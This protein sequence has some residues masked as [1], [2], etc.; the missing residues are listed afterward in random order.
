MR[1]FR[2]GRVDSAKILLTA[3]F[4]TFVLFPFLRMVINIKPEDFSKV[5][6]SPAFGT[7]A[8]N[9]LLVSLTTTAIS[10]TIAL[11]LA[12]SLQRTNVRFRSILSVLLVM[13][14]LIPS[15]SHG[16]GLMVLFGTNGILTKM[17]GLSSTIYGFSGMVTASVLYSYP[18]AF[19]MLNDVL[20]YEDA[21]PY[22]AAIVLGIPKGRRI[23]AITLP[24]L[25]RPLISAAFAVFTLTATDYGIPLMI[26]GKTTT[27]AVMMYQEVLGQLDF[28]KGSVV[29]LFLL[30]PAAIT[31][32]Y[33][34]LFKE[35]GKQSF[36]TRPFEVK[37]NGWRDAAAYIFCML[38]LAAITLLIASFCMM[39]FA[40]QYPTDM[41]FTW[42]NL[43]RM[44]RLRGDTYL[45]NSVIISICVSAV[46][47]VTAFL[48]AYLT[49]RLPS[50]TSQMLHLFSIAS[51]AIPGVVLGLSYSM[52]F[53]RTFIYGTLAILILANLMHFFASP[54]LLMYNSLSKMNE[55]LEDV[56]KTMGISRLHMIAAVIIPQ[57]RSTLL[58]MCSY[59]FVNS[60][61]T[62]SAV[63]FLATATT[64]PISLMINQ[65]EAQMQMSCAA[66]VSLII[67]AVNIVIKAVVYLIN[68]RITR[69]PT[70]A[71]QG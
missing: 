38:M 59:F 19:L 37:K 47:V 65:F 62:I 45:L 36:V 44:F 67:L 40:K 39:S 20:K 35:R 46:G 61:M 69:Q 41:T 63:S 8:L 28:G 6:S 57:C 10:L 64:K 3:V 29:G 14:M 32:V 50:R 1:K 15:I 48:T 60:M 22:E 55:N 26:G 2:I 56:G 4:I 53:S 33:N 23:S 21:S 25:R 66:V 12:F 31:F 34:T 30:I 71:T 70:V 43:T 52:A 5:L 18:S 58:E 17:F 49:T 16:M 7:A 11:L 9:T 27:L 42:D 24:Y 13:P 51:L 68:K 54:Y